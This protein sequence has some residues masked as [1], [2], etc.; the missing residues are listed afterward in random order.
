[1]NRNFRFPLFHFLIAGMA[2]FVIAGSSTLQADDWL[3]WRGPTQNGIAY[4]TNLVDSLDLKSGKNV[5]W[6]SRIGGRATPIILNDRVY[7]NCRTDHDVNDPEAKIHSREQVV[8]WDA[9]SGDELWRDE[10][11]VFQTDIPAPRVGWAAM[12]GDKDTG[13]V[14]VHSVSGIFRCYDEKGNVV[15]E[16]SLLEE[17]G[18]ISGYGGRTQTPI[19]DED[20]VI[21]SYLAANWGETKGPAPKH[22]YYAFDKRTGDLLWVS[23]PGGAPKDTNYS[24]PFVTVINGQRLLI[25]GNSDG[26]I[27]AINARTGQYVWGFQMSRRGLNS[28]PVSDGKYVYIAHGEDNVDNTEFGRIQCIDASLTGDI[29]ES[30]SVWRIDGVKAGY[31]GLLVKDGILYVVTDTGNMH[32]YDS[33]TGDQLWIQ[34]LGTVGKG[35]PVWADGKIYATETNGNFWV[36]KPS[37][38]GCEVL[39]HVEL[40]ALHVEGKDE[41]YAS[42]AISNGRLVLVTRDRTICFG[43]PGAASQGTIPGLDPEA[44][45]SEEIALVQLRPFEVFAMPGDNHTFTAHAFDANGRFVKTI[46]P[47]LSMSDD[48]L[49]QVSGNTWIAGDSGSDMAGTLTATVGDLSAA[50][51]VRVFNGNSSWKWDFEGLKG[52][53]VPPSWIR[54]HVKMKPTDVDGN[55]AMKMAGIG[56]GKGRPSH[57][58]WI[59]PP[60]MSDYTIQA[61]VL[62]KEQKRRL[63]NIG[64]CANRYNLILMGNSGKLQIQS[65]APHLRMSK[66]M[67]FRSDPDIWYRMK[68]TV[69]IE[70]DGAHVLGKV[71]NRDENEPEDWTIQTVDPH[72]NLNGSPGLYIYALADGYFDNVEVT[73]NQ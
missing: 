46:T 52:V 7:L 30:G 41:I 37:R 27:Y 54:A 56:S 22:Y 16:H 60:G 51:R 18:K 2:L 72:P 5:L 50:A 63:P 47:E 23:A 39:C 15:W 8:C 11:N 24:V 10:F 3:H 1:M 73:R 38:E 57:A 20:R 25:G 62:M 19:I 48:S 44:D 9:K 68:M 59:G 36:L 28:T 43:D 66:N 45:A 14:Y 21:V 58:V 53:A 61:D 29:T 6:E 65:W 26:G 55:I 13:C 69:K 42:I 34:D 67:S 12:C 35:S 17:Y 31:T 70:K 33:Q 32:A 64:I 4:E 49:G 40:D 71:W